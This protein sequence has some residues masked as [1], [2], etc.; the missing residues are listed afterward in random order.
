MPGIHSKP[1]HDLL[2]VIGFAKDEESAE[3][4]NL[5]Y[6]GTNLYVKVCSPFDSPIFTE[7]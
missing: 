3:E 1:E 2:T 7:H 6:D 5:I 4:S